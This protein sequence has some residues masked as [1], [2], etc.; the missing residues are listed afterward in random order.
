[1][2]GSVPNLSFF[3][4]LIGTHYQKHQYLC[5]FLSFKP[6]VSLESVQ[7]DGPDGYTNNSW[8]AQ[9]NMS[10]CCLIQRDEW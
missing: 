4:V 9:Q 8:V 2:F 3:I 10:S 5:Y 6:V 1:M 7:M